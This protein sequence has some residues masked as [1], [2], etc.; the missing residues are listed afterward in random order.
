MTNL[1]L[2][3]KIFGS[4]RAMSVSW[5][6]EEVS[7]EKLAKAYTEIL[8]LQIDETEKKKANKKAK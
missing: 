5:W 3:T 8:A 6:A 1:E 7:K 4:D 2:F